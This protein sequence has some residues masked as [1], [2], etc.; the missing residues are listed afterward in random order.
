MFA[1]FKCIPI[2]FWIHLWLFFMCQRNI[3]VVPL[4]TTHD[5][6]VVFFPNHPPTPPYLLRITWQVL[7]RPLTSDLVAAVQ[8][9]LPA[10]PDGAAVVVEGATVR[11]NGLD[12]RNWLG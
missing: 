10:S 2:Y 5:F 6:P 12:G 9:A 11:E 3:A 7:L 8:T 1:G 4:C